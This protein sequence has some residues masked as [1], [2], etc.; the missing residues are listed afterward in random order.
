MMVFMFMN[1]RME[2]DHSS[3]NETFE[4]QTEVEL[5]YYPVALEVIDDE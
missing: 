2:W 3:M 5:D 4:N 1:S